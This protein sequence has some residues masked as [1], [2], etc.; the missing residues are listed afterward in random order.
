MNNIFYFLF[1][2][3]L[4]FSCTQDK[5]VNEDYQASCIVGNGKEIELGDSLFMRCPQINAILFLYHDTVFE[6]SL[7][8][9]N[10]NFYYFKCTEQDK[11]ELKRLF[12]KY[13]D[14]NLTQQL[15]DSTETGFI[16]NC[17]GESYFLSQQSDQLNFGV[18]PM[19]YHEWI[20]RNG[21][22]P[23]KIS[24][25]KFPKM[26]QS[27]FNTFNSNIWEYVMSEDYYYKDVRT[28]RYGHL[29]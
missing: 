1:P 23:L 9:K 24:E 17:E 19:F 13:D 29:N 12:K 20:R 4:V 7:E 3:L 10:P 8:K 5:N 14:T 11:K 28:Y 25:T 15:T 2:S 18:I 21:I 22:R 16:G 6:A 26:Y 27:I